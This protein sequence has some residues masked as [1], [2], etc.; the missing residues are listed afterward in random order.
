MPRLPIARGTLAGVN[1]AVVGVLSAALYNP[2]WTS[3]ILGARGLAIA[4]VAFMLLERWRVPP[5]LIVVFCTG[6]AVVNAIV[7]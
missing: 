3:A 5:I 4:F 1:A 7:G 2:I 6:A